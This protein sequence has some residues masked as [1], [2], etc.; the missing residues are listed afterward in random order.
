MPEYE[1]SF[2]LA[3]PHPGP[4][5]DATASSV[6]GLSQAMADGSL[7]ATAVTRH[8]TARIADVNPALRAVIA[9]CPDALD[10][11]AR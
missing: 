3:P 4:G 6:A 10:P 11:V 9:A 8:Y 7:T 5:P 1:S 2:D